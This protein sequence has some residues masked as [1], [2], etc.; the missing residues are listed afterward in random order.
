MRGKDSTGQ[1]SREASGCGKFRQIS[2]LPLLSSLRVGWSEVCK[3]RD[4]SIGAINHLR[5][6]RIW[7]EK[8]TT[9]AAKI[10]YKSPALAGQ[11][12][13]GYASTVVKKGPP[14]AVWRHLKLAEKIWLASSGTQRIRTFWNHWRDFGYWCRFA[15]LTPGDIVTAA[16]FHMDF[17]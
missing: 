6:M 14:F 10:R 12:N 13:W 7:P 5:G 17:R 9:R 4:S 11:S 2:D 16:E 3:N 1:G 15:S 8:G